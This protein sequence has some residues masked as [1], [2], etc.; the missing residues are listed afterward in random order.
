MRGASLPPG[1]AHSNL[2]TVLLHVNPK[3]T[4]EIF[5]IWFSSTTLGRSSCLSNDSPADIWRRHSC[6]PEVSL[7]LL[8]Y[9]QFPQSIRTQKVLNSLPNLDSPLLA[10]Y[11]LPT[12]GTMARTLLDGN[13]KEFSQAGIRKKIQLAQKNSNGWLQ[14]FKPCHP[15]SIPHLWLCSWVLIQVLSPNSRWVL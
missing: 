9:A 10:C 14:G 15:V 12:L 7:L 6:P 2:R 3:S 4:S 5:T 13:D 11:Q 1:T 8:K